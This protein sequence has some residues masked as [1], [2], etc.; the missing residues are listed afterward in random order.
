MGLTILKF[1]LSVP[2]ALVVVRSVTFSPNTVRNVNYNGHAKLISSFTS[3]IEMFLVGI[4]NP[5]FAQTSHFRDNSLFDSFNS[6]GAQLVSKHIR[7]NSSGCAW[8]SLWSGLANESGSLLI[9]AFVAE[10]LGEEGNIT[11]SRS[12]AFVL[13]NSVT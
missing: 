2:T 5:L 12:L 1:D 8:V 4:G 13:E 6:Y 10:R 11:N 7:V 3:L 9:S